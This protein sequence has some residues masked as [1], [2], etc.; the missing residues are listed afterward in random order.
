MRRWCSSRSGRHSVAIGYASGFDVAVRF[1]AAVALLGALALVVYA[2]HI[3][4]R[5][6][7]W[8]TDRSWHRFSIGGLISAITWFTVG[9]AILSGRA[10][11]WPEWNRWSVEPVIAPLVVGWIGLAVVASASH[12]LPAVGPGSHAAHARQRV[13]LGQGAEARLVAA[14]VGVAG[15]I[16][17]QLLGLP[18]VI[19]VGG[20]AVAAS[21]F[22]TGVVISRALLIGFR[23]RPMG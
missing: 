1:G 21:F 22:A 23:A 19:E 14:N 20:L 6:A 17:G 12:L 9:M 3:W 15:L 2:A 8:T 5:R 7:L 18:V 4:T 11:A 10:I 16:A 13:V